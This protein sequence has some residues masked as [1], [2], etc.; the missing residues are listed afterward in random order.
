[1]G[2]IFSKVRF[3]Y[4]HSDIAG[5]LPVDFIVHVSA[6]KGLCFGSDVYPSIW[7]WGKESDSKE[8]CRNQ[9][10]WDR[11]GSSQGSALGQGL[12]GCPLSRLPAPP[13]PQHARLHFLSCSSLR[14]DRRAK[15]CFCGSPL[16]E[17][18]YLVTTT[19]TQSTSKVLG[20]FPPPTTTMEHRHCLVILQHRGVHGECV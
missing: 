11:R 18:S 19:T 7:S 5:G 12:R 14:A 1:M 16:Q 6:L 17:V 9:R 10:P 15:L 4:L 8:R 2:I 20:V 13:P 3:S